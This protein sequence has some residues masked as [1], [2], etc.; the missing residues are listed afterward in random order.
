[1]KA[2]A[3]PRPSSFPVQPPSSVPAPVRRSARASVADNRL[4][5]VNHSRGF[6]P[7][8]GA[9]SPRAGAGGSGSFGGR[10]PSLAYR[11]PLLPVTSPALPSVLVHV[12]P[13]SR[14][15]TSPPGSEPTL[16]L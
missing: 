14:K 12:L 10:P 4:G 6:S 5:G 3:G 9:G 8:A 7:W 16:R 11:W 13:S 1:M 15:D 2:I